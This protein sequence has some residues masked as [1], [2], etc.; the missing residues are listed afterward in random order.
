VRIARSFCFNPA[1]P[2][3]LNKHNKNR[4]KGGI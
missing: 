2:P 4:Q 3:I 1:R